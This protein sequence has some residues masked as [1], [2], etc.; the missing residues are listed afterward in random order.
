[1]NSTSA[2]SIIAAL[3][4]ATKVIGVVHT[5][6]PFVIPIARYT[7][8]K[9]VVA[10]ETAFTGKSELM[11]CPIFF[12]KEETTSDCVNEPLFKTAVTAWMSSDEI[13]GCEYL[14]ITI[15]QKKPQLVLREKFLITS[16]AVTKN[17]I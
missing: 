9:A 7:V 11:N 2:P 5:I 1:M 8:S 12:S 14:I 10:L 16:A 3:A 6:E 4:V 17:Y 15:L 13:L